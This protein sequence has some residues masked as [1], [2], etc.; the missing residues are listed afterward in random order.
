MSF[1][2]V[3][4]AGRPT[5]PAWAVGI[6]LILFT[7]FSHTPNVVEVILALKG[8]PPPCSPLDSVP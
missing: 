4:G 8:T 7:V 5:G 6:A 2:V 1:H 3:N